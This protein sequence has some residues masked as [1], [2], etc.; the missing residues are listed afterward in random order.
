ML[1]HQMHLTFFMSGLNLQGTKAPKTKPMAIVNQHPDH[2]YGL[3][4]P[5]RQGAASEEMAS[6]PSQ[7][8]CW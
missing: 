3:V 7:S 1:E 2:H 4:A 8:C 5:L 6:Y